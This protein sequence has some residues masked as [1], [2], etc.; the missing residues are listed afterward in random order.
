MS[1]RNNVGMRA[2]PIGPLTSH[3]SHFLIRLLE[4]CSNSKPPDTLPHNP[5]WDITHVYEEWRNQQISARKESAARQTKSFRERSQVMIYPSPRRPVEEVLALDD[6]ASEAGMRVISNWVIASRLCSQSGWVENWMTFRFREGA[7]MLPRWLA[8][9]RAQRHVEAYVKQFPKPASDPQD[10]GPMFTYA[11][12][13]TKDELRATMARFR[14]EVTAKYQASRRK[15]K[16]AATSHGPRKKGGSYEA[17][18][19]TYLAYR[20]CL[21]PLSKIV[22]EFAAK[23]IAITSGAITAGARNCAQLVDI[24][25]PIETRRGRYK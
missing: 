14:E 10:M 21:M 23:E 6:A 4:I 19:F 20:V 11:V 2:E 25:W 15:D 1:E 5:F 13:E 16:P 9:L 8:M 3:Q 18:H 12:P 17:N 22:E 7:P 24:F